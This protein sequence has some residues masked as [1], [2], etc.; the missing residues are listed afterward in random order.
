MRIIPGQ[1]WLDLEEEFNKGSSKEVKI[2]I[3]KNLGR[4]YPKKKVHDA[5]GR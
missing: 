1:E 2:V 4:V 3:P 5:E